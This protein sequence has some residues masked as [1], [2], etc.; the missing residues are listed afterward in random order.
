[1]EE[2][3]KNYIPAAGHDWAL[4]FY[5]TMMKWLG[6]DETRRILLKGTGLQPG[7]RIL[8]IGCGTGSLAV[9]VKQLY[10]ESLVVGLDPD[11]KALARA[12]RKAGKA[13][14]SIQFDQG[15]S[16]ELPYGDASIDRVFSSYMLHHLQGD[17]KERTL[18]E[19][20]RVLR[21]QG[22][23]CLL[24]FAGPSPAAFLLSP[25]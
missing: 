12:R 9:L 11:P 1:M 8:D 5:D 19:V 25:D 15:F 14:V 17:K 24:D 18:M 10:P 6:G 7:Q 16:Y 22:V 23:F 21:P 13:F 3:Q 4:P 20:R 2:I